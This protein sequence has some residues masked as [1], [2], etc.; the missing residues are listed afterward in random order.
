MEPNPSIVNTSSIEDDI[1]LAEDGLIEEIWSDLGGRIS[2]EV[3][4]QVVDEIVAE[5]QDATVKSFI[6]ILLQRE[7]RARIALLIDDGEP[8]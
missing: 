5:F 7:A 6:P 8:S 3:I 2:Q 4:R 1:V